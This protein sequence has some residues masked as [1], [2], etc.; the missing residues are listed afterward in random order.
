[1]TELSDR[2]RGVVYGMAIGDALGM[3]TQSFSP[4]QIASTYGDFS[5]FQAGAPTQPYAPGLPAG[6]VTDDTEQ[7][8]IIA[9]L[10]VEHG[11]HIPPSALADALLAWEADMLARG[12]HDLLGPSTKAALSQVQAGADPTTTGTQGVTNGAAMRVAPV[13]VAYS[14]GEDPHALCD[15]VYESCLVTHNTRQ[16]FTGAALV[17]A[18]VSAAV[19]GVPSKPEGVRQALLTAL[20]TVE[21]ALAGDGQGRG[22]G[23]PS[24]PREGATG[25][26]QRGAWV[27]GADVWHRTRMALDLACD[28]E[29]AQGEALSAFLFALRTQVGTSVLVAESVPAAFALAWVYAD[30]PT[31][32]LVTAAKIGGDTDTIGAILGAILG[33]CYGVEAFSEQM[34]TQIDTVN[35][36]DVERRVEGLVAL[37]QRALGAAPSPEA[38]SEQV[39]NP[40]LDQSAGR[41]VVLGQAIVDLA[42]MV[43]EWPQAGADVFASHSDVAVGGAFNV[44]FAAT[45]MHAPVEY[46]G[47][48]GAGPMGT[49]VSAALTGRGIVHSGPRIKEADT[50]YCVA[51]TQADGERTFLSTVGAE[52]HIAPDQWSRAAATPADVVY[53]DGYSLF[54][55]S[56]RQAVLAFAQAEA[57]R[58]A[59]VTTAGTPCAGA[60]YCDVGPMVGDA[61]V[62][63]LN[64]LAQ[65]RPVWSMN[66][67]ELGIFIGRLLGEEGWDLPAG[68]STAATW[69][70]LRSQYRADA[71]GRE[72]EELGALVDSVARLLGAPLVVRAG[73]RGTVATVVGPRNGTARERGEAPSGVLAVSALPV[74]VVDTNGAGD[75]FAGVLCAL[76]AAGER[77]ETA[78]AWASAAASLS[79]E[80]AGP[81]TCSPAEVVKTA[82][83][84]IY[85]TKTSI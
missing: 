58:Q 49:L 23:N 38:A 74:K 21:Y 16:G 54:H 17:A 84:D 31:A 26:G 75:T 6:T 77:W 71:V 68:P 30:D 48:V 7:A 20:E 65:I 56:T 82:V 12:S 33:A 1:M 43:D 41:V 53:I 24:L 55:D 52:T 11:G 70:A 80:S 85:T 35:D 40:S 47:A 2:A 27:E 32:G 79:V 36:L 15:A 73:A 45:M 69:D 59:Q 14:V 76:L 72:A 28:Y 81:A 57:A 42:L 19:D 5:T 51:V 44:M 39:L 25:S 8:L 3:P 78:L 9:D 37:R 50:G 64:A 18:A 46:R 22:E 4:E 10:L 62:A 63:A 34:R 83:E 29:A 67:R 66:E 60:V 13:G 61:P